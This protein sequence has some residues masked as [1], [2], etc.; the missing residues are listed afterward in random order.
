MV[1]FRLIIKKNNKNQ[2]IIIVQMESLNYIHQNHIN[3]K[4]N[5]YYFFKNKNKSNYRKERKY[6]QIASIRG[7]RL[8]QIEHYIKD[9]IKRKKIYDSNGAQF[10]LDGQIINL[11]YDFSKKNFHIFSIKEEFGLRLA[12]LFETIKT[13]NSMV[14]INKILIFTRS[15]QREEIYY[16]FSKCFLRKNGISNLKAY[17]ILALSSFS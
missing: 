5:Y 15:I 17:K 6:L 16:W 10:S 8:A 12:L 11:N 14:Q 2:K 13:S 7:W 1:K 9:L 4:N 3:K